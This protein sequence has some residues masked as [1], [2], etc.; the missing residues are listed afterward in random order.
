MPQ[1][2]P[3]ILDTTQF[4]GEIFQRDAAGQ[5]QK[6]ESQK[7]QSHQ[8]SLET[9]KKMQAEGV[10]VKGAL[11][12]K[13]L[14]E[15]EESQ[16]EQGGKKQK[17]QEHA[18][19]MEE[20]KSQDEK[21]RPHLDLEEDMQGLEEQGRRERGP[22]ELEEQRRSEEKNKELETFEQW[23][24]QIQQEVEKQKQLEEQRRQEAELQRQEEQTHQGL[25]KQ[26][27]QE[28][29]RHYELDQQR[30]QRELEE[31][32][33]WEEQRWQELE[34]YVRQEEKRQQEL[35]EKKQYQKMAQLKWKDSRQEHEKPKLQEDKHKGHELE[36]AGRPELE[37]K[38]HEDEIVHS[39]TKQLI[40]HVEKR[41]TGMRQD[42]DQSSNLEREEKLQGKAGRAMK[43][44]EQ[45]Q[46]EVQQQPP[47]AKHQSTD[48]PKLQEL[49]KDMRS[50]ECGQNGKTEIKPL[51]EEEMVQAEEARERKGSQ[52]LGEPR[53][54][55]SKIQP[56]L[57]KPKRQDENVH[58]E[59]KRMDTGEKELPLEEAAKRH[60]AKLPDKGQE[61]EGALSHKQRT[62]V[63]SQA[64]ERILGEELRWQEVDARQ[65]MPRGFT[66]QVSSGEKQ[67]IFQKVN[68]SPVIPVREA[69]VL[70]G[71][72]EQ[73]TPASSKGS[74]ALPSSLSAPHTAILVTGAQLCGT[75]VNLNQIKDTAC[76]SL[77]GLTEEKKK[78]IPPTENPPK[79]FPDV[80]P[81]SSKMKHCQDPVNNQTILA[82]WATI[83]SKILK[84]AESGIVNENVRGSFSRHSDD[85]TPKGETASHGNL[86]KTLSA[87]AKFSITPAW[88]KFSEI[89]KPNSGAESSISLEA[90]IRAK[91]QGPS[92]N[93]N[94]ETVHAD[95]LPGKA[96][97]LGTPAGK[98]KA[99]HEAAGSTE[100]CKFAKDLPSF[101]VPGNSHSL[102]KELAQSETSP[103]SLDSQPNVGL[104]KQ[105]RALPTGEENV[106]PFGVKLRRTN[107]SLRFHYDQ[108]AD[109]KKKKRYSAGDSFDGVP[110]PLVTPESEI[111]TSNS[112]CL[113]ESKSPTIVKDSSTCLDQSCTLAV[114]V[115]LPA[116]SKMS[117]LT[118]E[119]PV[120]KSPLMQKPALAPK[121]TSQTPPPSPLSKMRRA[122]L[123]E[124]TGQRVAKPETDP[125]CRKGE[126]KGSP[127]LPQGQHDSKM[128]EEEEEEESREKKSFFPSIT[129]P[130][131]EKPEKKPEPVKK[132]KVTVLHLTQRP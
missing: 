73:Q 17:L 32:N 12:H 74:H 56:P 23:E 111:D 106:S 33:W 98:T 41:E 90:E 14:Q 61:E 25:E 13:Q 72:N 42:L 21:K 10:K 87:N 117:A 82:E 83:R 114:P 43:L 77:L 105:D 126:T 55:D 85:W 51:Q 132:G 67:I 29:P 78:D 15:F 108:Q 37:Q 28:D 59:D 116:S 7:A 39:E 89:S 54:P 75:A 123:T 120:S 86:R 92:T 27:Q 2:E 122:H 115:S 58:A 66:F 93:V 129:M 121:P 88:Q 91:P 5:E 68:L 35:E 45:K 36:E 60:K 11:E 81:G 109:Q 1:L 26:K 100:G 84:T 49:Q 44:E 38:M 31:Q 40:P 50:S 3:G 57:A 24:E 104:R 4:E 80:K 119:K 30:K 20:S 71:P 124:S 125:S 18:M 118:H 22:L 70:S 102:W 79:T 34:D 6:S 131:R 8:R 64:Q 46:L 62:A 9:E 76:K 97:V 130:W 107:Y 48:D 63:D 127:L 53:A 95:T 101:L 112:I 65:T 19:K 128:E 94:H 16:R 99:H 52:T 113:K 69:S 103:S 47:E 110:S 96:N